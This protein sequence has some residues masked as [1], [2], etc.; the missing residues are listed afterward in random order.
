MAP[1]VVGFEHGVEDAFEEGQL[2]W[3]AGRGELGDG[4]GGGVYEGVGA[5]SGYLVVG[6]A[7]FE[8]EGGDG[9]VGGGE[10]GLEILLGDV[11][12]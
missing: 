8:V 12:W 1:G 11:V 3:G 2:V 7:D 5:G 10:V 4:I 9:G 6:T